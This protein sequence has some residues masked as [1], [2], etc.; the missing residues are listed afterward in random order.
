VQAVANHYGPTDFSVWQLNSFGLVGI[1][2]SFHKSFDELL[3]DLVGTADRSAPVMKEVSPVTYIDAQDPPI[4][5]LHGDKDP[6]VPLSQ[7]QLLHEQLDKAGTI[8]K[9][10]VLERSGHGFGGDK[11]TLAMEETIAFFDKHLKDAQ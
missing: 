1:R 3:A 5:T 2:Q 10:V 4:L 6:L 8:N 9:L 7:A 11:Y